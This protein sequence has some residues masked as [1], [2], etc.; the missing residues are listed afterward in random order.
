MH[1]DNG[2]KVKCATGLADDFQV[3]VELHQGISIQ[4]IPA[5]HCNGLSNR[6]DI[7]RGGYTMDDLVLCGESREQLETVLKT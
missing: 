7:K 1:Q 2:A 4:P 5:C 3:T 6:G